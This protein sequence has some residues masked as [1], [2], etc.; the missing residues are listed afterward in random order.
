MTQKIR[1]LKANIPAIITSATMII[2]AS[3]TIGVTLVMRP[4]VLWA[5]ALFEKLVRAEDNIA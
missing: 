1:K 3:F 2:F 5:W 4:D